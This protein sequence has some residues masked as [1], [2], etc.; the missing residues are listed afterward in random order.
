MAL[1]GGILGIS[2]LI[3][4]LITPIGPASAQGY[5]VYRETL[6]IASLN[7]DRL[8]SESLA[9]RA[10]LEDSRKKSVA[11]GEEN[12]RIEAEL[13]QEERDLT[14]LRKSATPEE[15]SALA[16]AFDD[17]VVEIRRTQNAKAVALGQELDAAR[18]EFSTRIRPIIQDLMREMGILFL[19]NEQAIVLALSSGDITDEAIAAVDAEIGAT[20][21]SDK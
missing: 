9:G 18:R 6:P 11:L 15:F 17:K 16:E 7:S 19:L 14:E 2:A 4:M 5:P 8:F 10:I 20:L 13:E 12:R 3:V 1:R 21:T